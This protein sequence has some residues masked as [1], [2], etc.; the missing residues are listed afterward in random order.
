[1]AKGPHDEIDARIR[2]FSILH[3]RYDP[4]KSGE[5]APGELLQWVKSQRDLTDTRRR[6]RGAVIIAVVTA[7]LTTAATAIVTK[8][9][10]VFFR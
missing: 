4:E 5:T 10:G 6:S 7:A 2:Q 8:G 1:M 9:W 3:L